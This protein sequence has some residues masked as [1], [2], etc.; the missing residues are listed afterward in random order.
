MKFKYT[1]CVHDVCSFQTMMCVH[2]ASTVFHS[3]DGFP[4]SYMRLL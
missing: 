1:V 3:H 2:D 4:T